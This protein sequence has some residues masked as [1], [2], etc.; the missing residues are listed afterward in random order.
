MKFKH[1]T[2]LLLSVP[3]FLIIFS[4]STA[5]ASLDFGWGAPII[6]PAKNK[7]GEINKNYMAWPIQISN[8]SK[9][10]LVPFLDIVAVTNTGKQYSPVRKK[11]V[12]DH[13]SEEMLNISEIEDKIF[14]D[15]TRRSIILF[16]DIDPKASIIHFYVGGLKETEIVTT[17]DVKYLKITYKRSPDGWK[18]DGVNFLE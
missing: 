2:M 16:S 7:Q 5:A 14:P 4:V 10:R 1:K 12:R 18:W 6:F 13:E 11:L 15:V 8:Y 9:H 17:K 3:L